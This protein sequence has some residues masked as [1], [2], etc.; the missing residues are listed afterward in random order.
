VQPPAAVVAV[1]AALRTRRL[2]ASSDAARPALAA[3]A[4]LR[5][6]PAQA[7]GSASP[8]ALRLQPRAPRWVAPRSN[9]TALERRLRLRVLPSRRR[10]PAHL[11]SLASTPSGARSAV[12]RSL[13]A[14]VDSKRAAAGESRDH[15][16]S[17]A[18][19]PRARVRVAL[20]ESP[21][22]HRCGYAGT[23]RPLLRNP[24]P[25]PV[26]VRWCHRR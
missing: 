20:T 18:P 7:G 17:L 1:E 23:R 11:R 2:P 3:R 12:A 21:P 19:R 26:F 24:S 9:R 6:A 8:P 16:R 14:S 4:A 15:G 22:A 13:P 10:P 25:P 5:A